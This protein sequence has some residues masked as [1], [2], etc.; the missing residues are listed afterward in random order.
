MENNNNYKHKY[1]S[2]RITPRIGRVFGW[3]FIGLVFVCLFALIF[4]FVVKWLWNMLMPAIFGLGAITFW[5]AFAL[6]VLAKL[7]FGSFSGPRRS[8][9]QSRHDWGQPHDWHPP[10]NHFREKRESRRDRFRD[11]KYYHQF[12]EEEG[13]E[14]FKAYVDGKKKTDKDTRNE[15]PEEFE[16][17]KSEDST[18]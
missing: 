6:V 1:Y 4:G 16:S 3:G 12:W 7:L 11:W 13:K 9:R 15:K 8:Y 5:Q 17:D 18:P 14:A 10:W 2:R